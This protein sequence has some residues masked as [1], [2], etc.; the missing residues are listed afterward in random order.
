[1]KVPI[2][3]GS[4]YVRTRGRGHEVGDMVQ[5]EGDGRETWRKINS[6]IVIITT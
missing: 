3:Y 2:P 4:Y 1:M 5:E 6:T